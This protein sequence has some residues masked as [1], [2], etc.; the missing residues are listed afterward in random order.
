V[1]IDLAGALVGWVVAQAGNAGIRLAR[2]PPDERAL[3]TALGLAVDWVVEQVAPPHRE[4]LRLGLRE[5]FSA[6][7]R[8]GL[9]AATAVDEGLRAAIA[10][11]VAQLD[12]LVHG[13]TGQPFFQTVAVD[14]EWLA[15][16]VTTA[17]R[18]ALRQVT[19]AG[20][21]SELVHGMDTAE[22]LTRLDGL[23]KPGQEAAAAAVATRTL[24]RDIGSF[25]GRDSELRQVMA[26]LTGRVGTGGVVGIHAIDGMAGIGKTAFAVHAAHQLVPHFPDGQI[27][28]RL[29]AHT[30]GQRPVEPADALATLLLTIGI[31]PQQ[32][33]TDR[34]ARELLWRDRLADRK[35]LLVFDDAD[36]YQQVD[37][38]L[39]G[40]GGSLVLITSRR[41]LTGL[42]D[43]LSIN[44]NI[45]DPAEAAELF[46][47]VADRPD[48]QPTDPAVAE[49]TRL[50]GYLP[51]AIR[52]MAAR[53]RRPTWTVTD[54]ATE[55]TAARDRLAVLDDGARSVAAAFDLSYRDLTEDQQQ[56]FRRLG[57]HPG[58][59]ID[60]YA[61]AAL[62]EITEPGARRYL[63]DLADLSLIEEPVRGRYRFHDLLGEYARSLAAT[64]PPQEQDAALDRLLDYYLHTA[65]LAAT[66]LATRTRVYHPRVQLV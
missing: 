24:P 49:V 37:P 30:P 36:G 23:G 41:R 55:L 59:E 2:R 45:L 13:D 56:M 63:E 21:L 64:D 7:P 16:Q 10:A 47:R 15:E 61:L 31:A 52:L 54:V 60:A 50:C 33:P 9:T 34:E 22:V 38:L 65:T 26:T 39:P 46:I 6:P 42:D 12:Q 58:A 44:L 11:Q 1:P 29:H 17:I 27:F 66:H 62:C 18:S 32:I 14:R 43:V 57:L 28:L 48:L 40:A 4:A 53:L 8:L 3:R 25:T 51:M 5:C 20:G 35:V 19:A